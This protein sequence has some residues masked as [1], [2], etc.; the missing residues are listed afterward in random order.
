MSSVIRQLSEPRT[1][2]SERAP[3]E[4]DPCS[5]ELITEQNIELEAK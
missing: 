1:I 5:G 4:S 3:A 2:D